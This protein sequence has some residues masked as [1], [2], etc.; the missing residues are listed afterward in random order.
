MNSFQALHSQSLPSLDWI[1]EA[2]QHVKSPSLY[3]VHLEQCELQVAQTKCDD[4]GT[5]TVK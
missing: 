2:D 1:G 5:Q 4:S 3:K